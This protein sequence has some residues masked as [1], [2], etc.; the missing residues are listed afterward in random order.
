MAIILF[1]PD[2]SGIRRSDA[3][4]P[5]PP[6]NLGLASEAW[7]EEQLRVLLQRLL[8]RHLALDSWIETLPGARAS[9]RRE[10]YRRLA[11]ARDFLDSSLGEAVDLASTAR[12]ACLSPH[13]FLRSF[14]AVF[15]LTPHQYLTRARLD[16]ARA[17]LRTSDRSVTEICCAV[18]FESLGS[19]S[20][21]SRR[22]VGA[23]PSQFRRAA[24]PDSSG[25]V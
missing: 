5:R 21:L 10:L 13:H 14:K 1:G 11:R 16:R 2:P 20:S 9:S 19:F 12:V 15:G 22:H 3:A 8:E 4:M 23:S 25:A 7:L 24:R 17:L 18:G 6:G